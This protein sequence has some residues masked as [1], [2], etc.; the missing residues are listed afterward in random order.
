VFDC[1]VETKPIQDPAI[2]R[3]L[4]GVV[5]GQG[6]EPAPQEGVLFGRGHAVGVQLGEIFQSQIHGSSL[7]R[8]M[9]MGSEKE[10]PSE[11]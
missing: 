8:K 10:A 6:A 5:G 9:S 1:R 2:L 7:R 11:A 3:A 4:L